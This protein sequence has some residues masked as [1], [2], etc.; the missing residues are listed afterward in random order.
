MAF[1]SAAPTAPQSCHNGSALPNCPRLSRCSTTTRSRQRRSSNRA[2][3]KAG[4]GLGPRTGAR[5]A[6][7]WPHT[8]PD[9]HGDG[10]KRVYWLTAIEEEARL[11]S[12]L[13]AF[14]ASPE[15]VVALREERQ[16]RWERIAA[17][18]FGDAGRVAEA[19]APTDQARGPGA[20]SRSY[21]GRGDGSPIW[22]RSFGDT[23]AADS[24][25]RMVSRQPL[26]RR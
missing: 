4:M 6:A 24:K 18:L 11:E 1:A 21:T 8:G 3:R 14:P 10:A 5:A 12:E 13:A 7:L 15:S 25:V 20:S 16:L 23:R 26:G 2:R 9:S 22:T 17:R 19:R